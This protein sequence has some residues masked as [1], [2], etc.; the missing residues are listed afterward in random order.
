MSIRSVIKLSIIF[1]GFLLFVFVAGSANAQITKSIEPNPAEPGDSVTITVRV[2]GDALVGVGPADI[3]LV[4]DRSGSMDWG[5]GGENDDCDPAPLTG[6]PDPDD[7]CKID[8]AKQALRTFVNLTNVEFNQLGLATYSGNSTL[9]VNLTDDKNLLLNGDGGSD[10]SNDRGVNDITAAGAT[11][12]GDGLCA[13]LDALAIAGEAGYTSTAPG[14]R[15]GIPG[16]VVLATDGK[17]NTP[18]SVYEKCKPAD[19]MTAINKAIA[20]EIK[21]YTISIGNDATDSNDFPCDGF[22][23]PS[24]CSQ[25]SDSPPPVGNGNGNGIKDGEDYLMDLAAKT[26]GKYYAAPTDAQLE[27]VY[28]AVL[29]EISVPVTFVIADIINRNVFEPIAGAASVDVT[30]CN[31]NLIVPQPFKM[32]P[33]FFLPVALRPFG[34]LAL[35]GTYPA[36]ESRCLVIR[37]QIRDLG[38]PLLDAA[39]G[40]YPCSPEIDYPVVGDANLERFESIYPQITGLGN[41][42]ELPRI[43]IPNSPFTIINPEFPW[44]KTT[45]GDVGSHGGLAEI[46][47]SFDFIDRDPFIPGPGPLISADYLL[48]GDYKI[49]NNFKSLRWTEEY[50][51]FNEND[52]SDGYGGIDLHMGT[53]PVDF[54][55]NT[56]EKKCGGTIPPLNMD[57]PSTAQLSNAVNNAVTN[58]GCNAVRYNGGNFRIGPAN[59]ASWSS[60]YNGKP[61][62][63]FV[64]GDFTVNIDMDVDRDTGLIF[65]ADNITI[66]GS[67]GEVDG[68][69]ISRNNFY[70]YPG[71]GCE[72]QSGAGD[73]QLEING[74]VYAFGRAC[75]NRD[76]SSISDSTANRDEAAEQIEFEPKYLF[77]FKDIIGGA[78][79]VIY[80]EVAP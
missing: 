7:P 35:L 14:R 26:G 34:V 70:T 3:M 2:P 20:M 43:L 74:A 12:I 24:W 39:C 37:T 50:Y 15:V 11:S 13:A 18:V 29:A 56:A 22:F 59:S 53:D 69:L 31:G 67:V 80:R 75:F 30:D 27:D 17:Q 72:Y 33:L 25:F 8:S 41:S 46:W 5:W 68:F 76:L 49:H 36:N 66:A 42:I 51:D 58:F 6:P 32:V 16:F 10:G 40:G 78:G 48:I 44:I 79:S 65:V 62:V 4:M 23:E 21:V 57:Q 52:P 77:L 19:T 71:R 28:R 63:V 64:D 55:R 54:I 61:A 60:G 1:I 38:D 45:L 47:S 73:R 9:D